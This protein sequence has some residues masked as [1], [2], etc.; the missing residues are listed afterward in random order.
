MVLHTLLWLCGLLLLLATLPLTLELFA[1]TAGAALSLWR[2]ADTPP[3]AAQPD[4]RSL[5]LAVVIPAHNEELLIGRCVASVLESA[6]VAIASHPE[7]T[8]AAVLV[9]A[10]NCSDA[11]TERA[12]AA[13]ASVLILNDP[14]QTGK[15]AALRHGFDAALRDGMEAV[16]VVDADSVV[17]S[18]LIGSVTANLLQ[19]SGALQCRYQVAN[20]GDTPRTR[21]LELALL[22]MNVLRPL[23]RSALGLSAGI[24]GN[25][26]ALSA[27]TLAGV[28][29]KS[30]SVV[31][32]LEYHLHLVSAKVR[33]DFLDNAT[34][35]GDMPVSNAGQKTQ[36]ARWEG[37]RARTRREWSLR[38]LL[39]LLK[40]NLRMAEPLVDLLALPLAT[41]VALLMIALLL[42]LEWLRIYALVGMLC[43]GAY[44]LIAAALGPDLRG[45]LLALSAAPRFILWKLKILRATHRVGRKD[46]VWIRTERDS[47]HPNKKQGNNN[48][49]ADQ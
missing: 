35:W 45:A 32:D 20:A 43:I 21:L 31:E 15:G 28:P 46:A 10:H 33:V 6:A 17:S 25:G 11:T 47:A 48:E 13:G 41:Q 30:D 49:R 27:Q 14:T 16:L 3:P 24:F 7:A 29:Y 23:G 42:P 39:E 37:G 22:G 38:L 1:L 5:R 8:S 4:T 18:N 19:G 40:G 34:V 12:T 44:L 26:F 2:C 36:R 9:V